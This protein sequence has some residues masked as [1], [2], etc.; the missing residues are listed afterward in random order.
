MRNSANIRIPA[1][2][3]RKPPVITFAFCFAGSF[4][5]ILKRRI[6]TGTAGNATNSKMFIPFS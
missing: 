5:I 2:K 3:V 4:F 6:T 1:F